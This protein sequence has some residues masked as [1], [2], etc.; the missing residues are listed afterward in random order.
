MPEGAIRKRYQASDIEKKKSMFSGI[1][2]LF[3]SPADT[4]KTAVLG[5]R[6]LE[7][8][9]ALLKPA[10]GVDKN[11]VRWMEGL[12]VND[13]EVAAFILEGDLNP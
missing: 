7:E 10:G 13:S 3:R 4:R 8:E 11:M 12:H 5:A 1:S 2:S 9:G 6:G